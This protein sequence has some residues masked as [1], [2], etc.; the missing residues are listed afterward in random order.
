MRSLTTRSDRLA[1]QLRLNQE[2]LA[3]GFQGSNAGLWD[4]NM[5]DG[6]VYYSPR[7]SQMLGYDTSSRTTTP[8]IF[9]DLLH[10]D[11]RAFASQQLKQHPEHDTRYQTEFRLRRSDGVYLWCR[12]RGKA[13]RD[14]AGVATRMVGS[15]VDITDLKAAEAAAF[16]EKEMPEVTLAAIA[17]A[18]VATDTE[19]RITYCNQVAE[20]LLG[21]PAEQIIGW[22]LAL[23]C[24]IFDGATGSEIINLVGPA[25]SDRDGLAADTILDLHRT[26]GGIV[27]IDHSVAPI[28]NPGGEIVGAVVV[29]HDVSQGR[30]QQARQTHQADHDALTG[31]PNRRAF[32]RHLN[33]MLVPTTAN[34]HHAVMYLDLDQFKV[35]NDT[36]GHAAGDELICQ[37]SMIRQQR[38]RERDLL[39]RLGGDELA[40]CSKTV[41]SKMPAAL[42]KRCDKALPIYVFRGVVRRSQLVSAL[43]W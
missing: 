37:V 39:A 34:R 35:I 16:A 25:L 36:C 19:A 40:F 23:A 18:V 28:R 13:V 26:D 27:P 31:A 1:A 8:A 17:D 2:R 3:L 29:L 14:E 24:R 21:Q 9:I 12:S 22:P 42:Q 10:P 5:Q 6:T 11:D 4:W 43:V 38:L 20:I 30:R 7:F 15:Q 32:E 33:A 41:C